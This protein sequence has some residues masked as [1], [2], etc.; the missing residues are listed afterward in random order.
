MP[1]VRKGDLKNALAS[2]ISDM[3]KHTDTRASIESPALSMLFAMDGM[4]CV[5]QN[6]ANGMRRLI[7]GTN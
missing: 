4:R 2:F 7:Q 6:D 5:Q 1:Y 3:K